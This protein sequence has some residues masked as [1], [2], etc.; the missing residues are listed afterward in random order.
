MAENSEGPSLAMLFGISVVGT[1]FLQ[2]FQISGIQAIEL[3]VPIAV[4]AGVV[5]GIE[6]GILLGS[7]SYLVL[8]L[9]LNT[10]NSE[11]ILWTALAAGIAGGLGGWLAQKK[12]ASIGTL[13]FATLAGTLVFE[14]AIGLY[15]GQRIPLDLDSFLGSAP[16]SGI[17]LAT[18]LVIAGLLATFL[19]RKKG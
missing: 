7:A 12:D 15:L 13:V 18:N 4:Y 17:H 3:V 14:L 1:A 19:P 16:R 11:L 8:G 9:L 5:Y 2:A 6:K 10:L